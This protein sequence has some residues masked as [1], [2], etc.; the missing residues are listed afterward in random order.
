MRRGKGLRESAPATVARLPLSPPTLTTRGDLVCG[1]CRMPGSLYRLPFTHLMLLQR[2]ELC[3]RCC[4]L[5][6]TQGSSLADRSPKQPATAATGSLLSCSHPCSHLSCDAHSASF[7]QPRS[8]PAPRADVCVCVGDHE[9]SAEQ[10]THT[11]TVLP[12]R[13]SLF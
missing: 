6:L 9:L 12:T 8:V 11:H 3:D 2:E 4:S 5:S 13:S 10:L 7:F 1:V